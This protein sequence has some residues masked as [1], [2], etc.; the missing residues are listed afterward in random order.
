MFPGFFTL[1]AVSAVVASD[2][3]SQSDAVE[4]L[5]NLIAKSLVS[6]EVEDT[7]ARYR[8]LDTTR[9]YALMKLDESGECRRLLDLHAEYL[10]ELH[11]RA[12]SGS[13][14]GQPAQ[15]LAKQL[16][17]PPL[18]LDRGRS[19]SDAASVGA[20]TTAA[21]VP[22]REQLPP[23]EESRG[24]VERAPP[25]LQARPD[26]HD[27]HEEKR[28]GAFAATLLSTGRAGMTFKAA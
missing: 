8:L 9:I 27:R 6:M 2:G 14:M 16:H 21:A 22:P 28:R 7:I 18:A 5:A 26:H 12:E 24:R 23:I 1:E 4:S 15:W 17:N 13:E 10:H 3:L 20:A 25:A 19:P 11:E